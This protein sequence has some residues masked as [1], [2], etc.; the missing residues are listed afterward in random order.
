MRRYFETH[1]AS[2]VSNLGRQANN[3]QFVIHLIGD[4]LYDLANRELSIVATVID[5][6]RGRVGLIDRQQHA[7]SQIARITMSHQA[8]TSIS[9][10][11]ERTP[12][13]Q[14]SNHAPLTRNQLIGP[15]HIRIAVKRAARMRRKDRLL[16]TRN[17]I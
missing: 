10:N 1:P 9:Q 7:M 5:L 11:H 13:E 2:G 8:E 14:T 6:T 12:I 4:N 15:I 16:G 17:Q 3:L